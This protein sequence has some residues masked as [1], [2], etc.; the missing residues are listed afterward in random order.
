MRIFLTGDTH[1]SIDIKRLS[2]KNFPIQK[3]LTKEDV[4]IILGDFGLIWNNDA[5]DLYWQKWLS[6]KP[7]TTLFIDGN[8]ENFNLLNQYP[9]EEKFGG[10]VHK[11]TDSIY[12]LMRGEVFTINNK[13][14]F[15]MGGAAS[16]D[17][18]YRK[19]NKSWWEA[20]MPDWRE[21]QNALVN[22]E[23]NDWTVDYVLTHCA[24]SM[25]LYEIS[26]GLYPPDTYNNW[27]QS[28]ADILDFD[29]WFCG[30]YH[31]NHSY[32]CY[33]CLYKGIIELMEGD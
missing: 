33:H 29:S 24:P 11:I 16:S 9:V 4:V 15:A 13:T 19:I 2:T 7:F 31:E 27:L 25:F 28:V 3:D 10:K 5:E 18:A 12:H 1:G 20:E 14:F 30:H 6:K 17:K 21:F 26:K 22:L 23:E 8:H 32:S